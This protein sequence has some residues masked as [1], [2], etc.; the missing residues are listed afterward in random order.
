M[1]LPLTP[2]ELES[3]GCKQPDI[4]LLTGDAYIDSS[5]IGV[6]VIGRVLQNAG[7]SVAV[8]SQPDIHSAED[9]CRFGEPKLFW[10]VSGGCV[11]SMISN[12]TSSGKRRQKD[13]LTP[14]GMNSRRPDRAVIVYTNL[15][16]GRFKNT[17]P[18][19]LGG[20]EASLR[21]ISHYDYWSDSVKRSILFDA[22]A[23][24][25]IYGMGEKAVL[26]LASR[27]RNHE[28]IRNIRGLC[29][30][31]SSPPS[32]CSFLDSHFSFLE[33]PSHESV[34]GDKEK[35]IEMFRIFYE[36]T[37]PFTAKQ[38][39]QKQDSRYLI[40]NP[41][42]FPLS[43]EELDEIYELPYQRKVHPFCRKDGEVRALE[44]IRFS[45]T[46]HRGC[47]GECRFCAVTAHQ[48]RTVTERSQAS[49]LREAASFARHPDFKG[50]I[51]DVGG[52]SANMYATDCF[53]KRKQGACQDKQCLFP[54]PCKHLNANH[55]I[56]IDLLNKLRNLSG[57]KKVFIGSGIRYDL[58]LKDKVSGQK[59]LEQII[60]HHIS[61][62]LKIAP[63]HSQDHILR[64]MG[65]PGAE[66]LVDFKKLFDR[67]NKK[68]GKKQFLTY[69]F[70]AAHPG[71]SFSDMHCLR[72]FVKKELRLRPEQIQIFTPSPSTWSALMYYTESD[73]FTGK[74][75]FV[76]KD[77]RKKEK[78][79]H[80]LSD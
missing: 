56:Q 75:L 79:K 64:L 28:D 34:C 68:S 78:Q 69:Y 38:L 7:Y 41:P 5:Y 8:I 54:E 22:K 30:I 53:K 1:F 39:Y 59:Y 46:A 4:I 25:L 17:K 32:Y 31:S 21:R 67:I 52:P 13:D 6:S 20:I 60:R 27:L 3:L 42:Q 61:G 14:G 77:R 16:K 47:Y 24:F 43:P 76:E 15:I 66:S 70:I 63:E 55:A 65:K 35:F 23:D 18:I 26:E 72:A 58:I 62:Q 44:T 50:I 9:I 45:L 2:R 51:S 10:G 37:D 71:C 36:N 49:I 29:Y 12:Y 48:G 40:Q 11:D 73:P 33:I 57:I 80:I 74:A 19:V